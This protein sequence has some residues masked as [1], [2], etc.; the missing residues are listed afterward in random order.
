MKLPESSEMN[1][2]IPLEFHLSQNYPNPFTEKTKIKYCIAYKTCVKIKVYNSE[3]ELIAELLDEEK[4][5]GTYEVEF[6]AKGGSASG[7]NAYNLPSGIYFYELE[8]EGFID[9]KEMIIKNIK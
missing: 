5:A 6:F 2:L 7:G 3:N 8:T 9:K 4:N 1:E